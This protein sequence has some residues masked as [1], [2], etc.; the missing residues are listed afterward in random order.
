MDVRLG[1]LTEYEDDLD[2]LLVHIR[3]GLSTTSHD[4]QE[5]RRERVE[6][7]L[8]NEHSAEVVLRGRTLQL[9]DAADT[10]ERMDDELGLLCVVL[11]EEIHEDLQAPASARENR[12]ISEQ[13]N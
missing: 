6:K 13:A 5:R 2:N 1:D 8:S 11:I 3:T 9:E 7:T 10:V 12:T 4:I